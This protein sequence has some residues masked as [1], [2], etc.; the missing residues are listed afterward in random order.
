MFCQSIALY[1]VLYLMISSFIPFGICY[2]QP[3][4]EYRIAILNLE[5]KGIPQTAVDT[6]SDIFR[7]RM[8]QEFMSERYRKMKDKP[9]YKVIERTQM[10]KIFEEHAIQQTGCVSDSCAIEFGKIL[11]ANQVVVG[12]IGLVGKTYSVAVR[13]VDVETGSY[14][15]RPVDRQHKGSIDDIMTSVIPEVAYELIYGK[16]SKKL[17][18]ILGV[19]AI[20]AGVGAAVALGGEERGGGAVDFLPFPP[21]RP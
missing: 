2:A 10:N 9:Q 18:Y 14:F 3:Y 16:R 13:I 5:A 6:I 8:T 4:G 1:L 15:G 21:S 17:Y 20:A 19:I 7:T 12:T 11:G